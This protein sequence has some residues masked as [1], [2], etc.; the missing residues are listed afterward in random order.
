MTLR[1]W[2]AARAEAGIE[3]DQVEAATVADAVAEAVRRHGAGGRLEAV[4][5]MCSVLV[6]EVPVGR[7]D[8]AEVRLAPGD[9]VEFLPP[10]AGG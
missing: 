2:A 8:R 6:G 7:R 1:F 5:A 4:L 9:V 10:F 3:S